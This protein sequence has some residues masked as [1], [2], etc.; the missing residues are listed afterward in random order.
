[1]VPSRRSY[2]VYI[3]ASIS[4]TLYIGVTNNLPRRIFEH[5]QGIVAG[6]TKR[7]GCDRLVYYE[8]FRL[9][10]NAIRTREGNKGVETKQEGVT[11]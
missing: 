3:V 8:A 4:G 5:K 6:F 9:V 7:Y 2:F 1:M 11:N 10:E